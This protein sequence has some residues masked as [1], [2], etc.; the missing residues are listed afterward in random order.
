ML[1]KLTKFSRVTAGP[2]LGAGA[3]ANPSL[4]ASRQKSSDV[5]Q[6][7]S[8]QPPLLVPAAPLGRKKDNKSTIKMCNLSDTVGFQGIINT[9]VHL[10]KLFVLGRWSDQQRKTASITV[11]DNEFESGY[12]DGERVG[13][14]HSD[15]LP[16][17]W[18]ACLLCA[19]SAVGGS[20]E[21]SGYSGPTEVCV[22]SI[23]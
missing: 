5:Q 7:L 23:L 20:G 3:R 19:D 4:P 14:N 13:G 11:L 16:G 17:F 15:K 18:A 1:V 9:S 10:Q 6:G 12:G 21:E 2:I 22:I 8:R